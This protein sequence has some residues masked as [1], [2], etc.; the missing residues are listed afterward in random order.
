MRERLP[1]WIPEDVRVIFTHDPAAR[2]IPEV[3]FCYPGLHAVWMHRVAHRLWTWRLRFLAR[4]FSH[5]NRALTGIEIHPGAIVGRRVFV[6]HGMGVVIG[7]TTEIG[8]DVTLYQGVTLGGTSLDPGK[9]HPT[10]G[11]GVTVGAGAKV[12]GAVQI[13][14]GARIGSGAIV[15]K[16]VPFG[17]TVVG[18]AGRV[19][20][21]EDDGSRQ[22]KVS[23]AESKGD[24][25]VRALE[26]LFDKM[27]QLESRVIDATLSVQ[28]ANGQGKETFSEG[29]GI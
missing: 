25:D 20:S 5:V 14:A 12:L 1:A 15:V 4:F 28:R 29:A 18:L 2:S 19:L 11:N 8:D 3:L 6:D 13:G 21:R 27:E 9:R 17:A 7:E 26:V 22:V 23:L 10:L 16:D 24:H